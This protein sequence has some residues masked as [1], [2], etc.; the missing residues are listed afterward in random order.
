V[1][2]S[3]MLCGP[4]G[5]CPLFLPNGR[6]ISYD[7]GHLTKEGAVLLGKL[8]FEELPARQFVLKKGESMPV[9]SGGRSS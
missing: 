3:G 1:N 7:G 2:V 9:N 5:S 8:L 4:E 6:L